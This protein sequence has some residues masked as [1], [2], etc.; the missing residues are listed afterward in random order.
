M[1]SAD[2]SFKL[3]KSLTFFFYVG[4]IELLTALKYTFLH[5]DP[6]TLIFVPGFN[7]YQIESI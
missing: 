3:P 1:N 2:S 5:M 7:D 6:S 4:F